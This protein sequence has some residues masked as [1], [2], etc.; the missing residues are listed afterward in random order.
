MCT[1]R[2]SYVYVRV[3]THSIGH[4]LDGVSDCNEIWQGRYISIGT[5]VYR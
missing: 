5:Y 3:C 2:C 1:Y 4:S